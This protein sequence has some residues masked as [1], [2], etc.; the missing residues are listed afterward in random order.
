MSECRRCV[1]LRLVD[2]ASAFARPLWLMTS[3]LLSDPGAS[4]LYRFTPAWSFSTFAPVRGLSLARE[5]GMLLVWDEANWLYLVNHRG[6]RQAQARGPAPIGAA[7]ASD[8]GSTLVAGLGSGELWLLAPDLTPARRLPPRR[9]ALALALDPFGRHIALSDHRGNLL[10]LA[11]NG[12]PL[13]KVPQPRPLLQ[14]AFIPEAPF[15]VGC[16]DFGL[17]VCLEMNGRQLWRDGLAVH[18]GSLAT[19][20][21]GER[22]LLACYSDGVR[23][24]AVADGPHGHLT[25]S[26]PC[27]LATLSF[28]GRLALV[29]GRTTSLLALDSRGRVLAKYALECPAVALALS[30]LGDRAVVAQTNGV[31][32]ALGII[33]D[34]PS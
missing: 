9:P 22:I 23:R 7:C 21:N 3:S 29:A 33:S 30:A 27:R 1:C 13:C 25:T 32:V 31:V 5:T 4:S 15:L 11:R 24:Y 8:D 10:V 12:Q 18:C 19:S 20:G 34:F 2:I 28:D 16:A 17:V 14:L 6:E 26:E